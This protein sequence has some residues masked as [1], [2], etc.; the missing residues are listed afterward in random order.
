MR[1]PPPRRPVVRRSSGGAAGPLLFALG[2]VGLALVAVILARPLLVSAVT[3]LAEERPGMLKYAPVRDFVRSGLGAAADVPADPGASSRTFVVEPGDTVAVVARRLADSHVISRPIILLLAV[4]EAGSEESIQAG[5]YRV[6]AAMKP[7]ELADIFK[8]AFGEQLVLRI[9]EGW[10]LTEIATE[11]EKRFP[12]IK[13]AD[14]LKAAVTGPYDYDFLKDVQAGT[15]L[16]GFLFPDTYFFSTDVTSDGIV[17]TLLDSFQRRVGATVMAA[18]QRR[19]VKP[20]DIVII[21]SIVEREARDRKESPT[22]AS[23]YWNRVKIGMALQADPTVQYA[24][25]AWRELTLEDLKVQS[26]YNTYQNPGLPPTPIAMAGEAAIAGA[27]DPAQTDYLYFVA[28]NDGTG[29]HAFA[30]T[31]AE[32][33]AN[34]VKYGNK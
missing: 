10:R 16:E 22:I 13:A 25:G 23:V 20:S 24:V 21:A 19:K 28:K 3:D 17:R 5:T 1:A 34:R 26:P 9:I 27:A 15:P 6:S 32:Q 12:T 8:R 2:V 18:A 14:F 31:N 29:D 7:L 4:Y 33:E 30:R 11:V